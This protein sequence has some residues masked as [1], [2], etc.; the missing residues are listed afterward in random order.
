MQ[1]MFGFNNGAD[2]AHAKGSL[3]TAL[4]GGTVRL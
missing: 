4:H 1:G 2:A 3:A